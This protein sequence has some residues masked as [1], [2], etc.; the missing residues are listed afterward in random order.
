M[1]DKRE[2]HARWRAL[3]TLKVNSPTVR[4]AQAAADSDNASKGKGKKTTAAALLPAKATDAHT[5]KIAVFSHLGAGG[6]LGGLS[7]SYSASLLIKVRVAERIRRPTFPLTFRSSLSC[8]SLLSRLPLSLCPQYLGSRLTLLL[9]GAAFMVSI[10]L[11][12]RIER[13]RV[14]E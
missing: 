11:C 2:S 9:L 3:F 13:E 7:G 6:T 8:L 4:Q 5:K 12:N 10:E 1:H 14:S